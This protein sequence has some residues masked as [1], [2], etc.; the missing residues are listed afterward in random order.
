MPDHSPR[1]SR[2]FNASDATKRLPKLPGVVVARPSPD[3]LMDALAADLFLQSLA[4]VRQFGDFHLALS[5]WPEAEPFFLRLL[6][7]PRFRELPWTR[8]HLWIVEET[9]PPSRG[10]VLQDAIVS[11]SDIPDQ[12]VHRM[13]GA[14]EHELASGYEAA[15]KETLGWR[16]KGHDRLD[17]ALL[18]VMAQGETHGVELRVP[19]APLVAP[20]DG[21]AAMSA[22]LL[23][24]TRFV[25]M[26]A[27]GGGSADAIRQI[28]LSPRRAK[29]AMIPGARLH[30]A[31][32][33]LL[34]GELR[35]YIDHS[36]CDD[37]PALPPIPLDGEPPGTSGGGV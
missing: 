2:D 13:T 12:Q 34:G 16:E 6:Y 8:T 17:F 3:E 15:L 7:D 9:S 14:S 18:P 36:V 22:R 21:A 35:W 30:A 20:L 28:D 37:A 24:A 32:L 33:R 25:A 27:L 23:N 4:C 11:H 19:D 1:D 29:D 10:A 5:V 26:L 31:D